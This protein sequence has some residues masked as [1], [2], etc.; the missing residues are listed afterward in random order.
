MCGAVLRFTL[1]RVLVALAVVIGASAVTWLTFRLLLPEV[2]ADERSII[3]G[4]ADFL[5][6]LVQLDL[7]RA[8]GVGNQTVV[9]VLMESLPADL[10]LLGGAMVIGVLLGIAGGAVCGLNPRGWPARVLDV[11]GVLALCAPVYWVGLVSILFFSA[12]IGKVPIPFL[13]GQ[14]T[15]R[16]LSEDPISWLHGLV[17]PWLVLALPIAAACMRMLRLSVR[18]VLDE[19]FTRTALG[20]GLPWRRV[21]RRH[22][23]PVG[24]PPVLALAGTLS[25]VLVSNAVLI[26]QTFNIP[27]TLRLMVSAVGVTEGDTLDVNVL[28]GVVIAG[29]TVVVLCVLAAELLHAWLDPRVRQ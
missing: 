18:E 6:H 27:G 23:I 25:A 2:V 10:A 21:V 28:Q 12:E 22:V 9:D 1:Q 17:L 13:G 11:V 29:A 5:W 26:E 19:D 3:V 15:Y 7:G 8:P 4:L 16:P 20:K 24:T 14:G